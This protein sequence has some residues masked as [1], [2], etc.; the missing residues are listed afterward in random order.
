MN[1]PRGEM[2]LVK[3]GIQANRTGP[4][5]VSWIVGYFSTKSCSTAV[6]T[7]ERIFMV[8]VLQYAPFARVIERLWSKVE[9]SGVRRTMRRLCVTLEPEPPRARRWPTAGPT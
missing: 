3:G 8:E 6:P 1:V 5:D 4:E 9:P 2:S 7:Y